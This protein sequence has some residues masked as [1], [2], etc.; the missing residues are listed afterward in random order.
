MATLL[1]FINAYENSVM[2]NDVV[3]PSNPLVAPIE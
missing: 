3:R 1:V 2:A